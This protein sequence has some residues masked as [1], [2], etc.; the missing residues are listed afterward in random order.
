MMKNYGSILLTVC[1][2]KPAQK[3]CLKV[4]ELTK[5]NNLIKVL[6]K[7]YSVLMMLIEILKIKQIIKYPLSLAD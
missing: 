2:I 1:F 5:I 7:K 3:M 4:F 6:I